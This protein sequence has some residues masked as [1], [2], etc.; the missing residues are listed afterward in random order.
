MLRIGSMVGDEAVKKAKREGRPGYLLTFCLICKGGWGWD[1]CVGATM[2]AVSTMSKR[3]HISFWK[4]LLSR[5]CFKSHYFA[6][7][8]H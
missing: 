3:A 1:G 8:E 4:L 7:P 5:F 6:F 2:G